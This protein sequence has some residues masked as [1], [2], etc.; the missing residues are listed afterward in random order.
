M[1]DVH[2]RKENDLI[3][4]SVIVNINATVSAHTEK[5][6]TSYTILS[7]LSAYSI[8]VHENELQKIEKVYN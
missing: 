8:K 1:P 7:Y 3:S 2:F 4:N 5:F 6:K